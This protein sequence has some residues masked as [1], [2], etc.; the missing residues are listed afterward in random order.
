M[1]RYE[2]AYIYLATGRNRARG[3]TDERVVLI[4]DQTSRRILT[5]A[6]A[7]IVVLN[8]LGLDGWLIFAPGEWFGP[9]NDYVKMVYPESI[10]KLAEA[11]GWELDQYGGYR[12][13]FMRRQRFL[14]FES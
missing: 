1:D 2:Y 6:E 11:D 3:L 8:Q 7:D 14:S 12:R 9:A 5:V 10:R 13:L 4:D